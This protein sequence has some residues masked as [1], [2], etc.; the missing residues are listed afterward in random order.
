[1]TKQKSKKNIEKLVTTETNTTVIKPI[2]ID[3]GC[4]QNRFGIFN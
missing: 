2:R 1:M 3:F 4:G